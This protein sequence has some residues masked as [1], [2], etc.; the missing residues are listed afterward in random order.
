MKVAR[1]LQGH[2]TATIHGTNDDLSEFQELVDVLQ[3]KVGRLVFNS[4]PTGVE[5]CAARH[6]G[7]RIRQRLTYIGLQ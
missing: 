6:H 2:L 3:T 1:G 4:F 5:V 7:G